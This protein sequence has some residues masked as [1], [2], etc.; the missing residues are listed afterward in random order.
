MVPWFEKKKKKSHIQAAIL[1]LTEHAI[2]YIFLLYPSASTE[3][4]KELGLVAMVRRRQG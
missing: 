1:C 4:T 3:N 2:A